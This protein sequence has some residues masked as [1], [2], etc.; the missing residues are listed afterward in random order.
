MTSSRIVRCAS[1]DHFGQHGAFEW[2]SAC[3]QR[4]K[5]A[6]RPS[7]GPPKALPRQEAAA[8]ARA[9]YQAAAQGRRE[10]YQELRS[11]GE[12]REQAAARLGVTERTTWRY[13]QAQR[14]RRPAP[15]HT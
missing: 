7:D 2:C 14:L 13:E 3:Y 9:A 15:P 5:K 8:R 12:T 1:C 6:G 4:W 10:D 11:W